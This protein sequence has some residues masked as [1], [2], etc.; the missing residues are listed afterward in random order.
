MRSQE[1]ASSSEAIAFV[2]TITMLARDGNEQCTGRNHIHD[3]VLDA[4]EILTAK[5]VSGTGMVLSRSSSQAP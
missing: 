1:K 3:R 5:M 2:T 4:V